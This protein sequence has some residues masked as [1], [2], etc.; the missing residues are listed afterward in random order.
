M[1]PESKC[2]GKN[3]HFE[4]NLKLYSFK[5]NETVVRSTTPGTITDKLAL[6]SEIVASQVSSS[7]LKGSK[8]S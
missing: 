8:E 5:P 3:K 1:A 4:K 6:R 7:E 2:F